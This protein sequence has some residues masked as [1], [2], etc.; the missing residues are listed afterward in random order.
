MAGLGI[1]LLSGHTVAAEVESGR[2]VCLDVE[3]LPIVRRWYVL[4]RTDRALS[5][6]ARAFRDFAVGHG[7][8]FLPLVARLDHALS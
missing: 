6:A 1:A 2:L 4:N 8:K 5:P 7:S 3:D